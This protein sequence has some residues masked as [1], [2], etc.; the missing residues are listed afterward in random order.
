MYQ[1]HT[2]KE[3]IE[4]A[5]EATRVRCLPAWAG[6]RRNL[7]GLVP[8]SRCHYFGVVAINDSVIEALLDT[9]GAKSLVDVD[10]AEQ[11]GLEVKQGEAG[12]FWGPGNT[13]TP[14]YGRVEGPIRLQF[15]ETVTLTIPELKVV[16][17]TRNDPLL[18]L[19]CD[20]MTR[21]QE[22]EW[23]FVNIG[24]HPFTR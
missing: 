19:G 24:T 22:G 7:L 13:A 21:G 11:M 15:D 20:F 3:V 17:G 18:I 5:T 1:S 12:Y 16:K 2:E 14:Y 6:K 4:P 23:D 9:G 8:F 10:T